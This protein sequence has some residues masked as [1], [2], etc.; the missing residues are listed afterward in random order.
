MLP[1]ELDFIAEAKNA[2]KTKELFKN[3]PN[4]EVINIKVF[5]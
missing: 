2:E 5:I 1:R 4:I 3:N